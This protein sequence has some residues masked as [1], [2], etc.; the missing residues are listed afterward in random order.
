MRKAAA[1]SLFLLF[2][3]FPGSGKA[4]NLQ[5]LVELCGES[6]GG[7]SGR[8]HVAALA[9]DAALGG[10]ATAGATGS[11]VPG[12]AST[13]GY[14][15]RSVPRI[16]LSAK[17]GVTRYSMP[18]IL[19]GFSVPSRDR[20]LTIP[21]VQFSGVMGV[22]NGFSPIPTVGG[23]LSLDLTASLQHLFT[24]EDDGFREGLWGW[25]VGARLGLLRESFTLP[26]VSVSLAHR[27]MGSAAYGVQ[28]VEIPAR[29]KFQNRVTS[30]R[31][32][33]G[34]DILGFGFLAGAGWDR[35]SAD[36]TLAI[37]LAPLGPEVQ[38]SGSGLVSERL[39]YFAGVSRTFLV[40][41][42]SGEFG[43]SESF[44]PELPL[45]PGGDA[46]PSAR[47]VYGSLAL[48]LTF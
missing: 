16:A 21:T 27:W 40:L 18:D 11:E 42:L 45:V 1:K 29:L 30:L 13:M 46:Y 6:L 33:V 10:V 44:D 4:Q 3:L 15:L 26:G 25:G 9:L 2:F 17:T 20:T 31:G 24:P 37:R 12:S 19:Q 47:A 22:L 39:T 32:V 7:F 38:A 8:C 34:K 43:W 41:Q 5:K 35:V 48:R 14:R 28:E 23:V 36:G